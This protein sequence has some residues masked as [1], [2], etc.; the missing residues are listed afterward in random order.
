MKVFH[1]HRT[2]NNLFRTHGVR[3][4][5]TAT[6]AVELGHQRDALDVRYNSGKWAHWYDRDLKYPCRSVMEAL[7]RN[8]AKETR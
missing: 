6:A 7:E 3:A 1:L 2:V 8:L 5:L 4:W